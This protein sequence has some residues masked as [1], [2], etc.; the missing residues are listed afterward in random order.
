M[1][2]KR[3]SKDGKIRKEDNFQ[4]PDNRNIF[5]YLTLG[6]SFLISFV[7]YVLTLAPSV[8]FED[9]GELI[10][11]AVHLGV[12]HEPGYPLYTM[13]GKLFSWLPVGDMAY[14]LN[15][16]SA[17]FSSL[18]AIL[19]CRSTILII[20]SLSRN[21]L[22]SLQIRII[23]Y[24]IGLFAAL[25]FAFSFENWEQSVITEV[26]GLHMFFVGL[27]VML[28]VLW[29]Q[30]LTMLEKEKYFYTIAFSTGLS[31]TNHSTALLFIPVFVLYVL[32]V[33]Y[34]FLLNLKRI[35]RGIL[36]G[37][38]GLLP[39]LYLPL[40]SLRDPVLD[41][42][43]PETFTNFIRT[44]SRHQY[45][46]LAQTSEKFLNGLQFYFGKLLL[47]QWFSFLLLL[48]IPASI[49]LYKHNRKI[50]YF[51]LLFLLFYV[52]VT[53][54]LTDFEVVGKGFYFNLNRLLVTVFYIPSYLM[55]SVLMGIG[56]F[57]VIGLLKNTN[58]K[59]GMLGVFM[60]LPFIVLTM[61]YKT[62][63]MSKFTYPTTYLNNLFNVVTKDAL[64]LTQIDYF[65]FPAMY[66]QVVEGNRT[67][68]T[69]L[70]QPLLKRTWYIDML[71]E[72]NKEFINESKPAV[73]KF[74]KAVAPFEA[75]KPYD[76]NYIE[77]C[78]I[79]MINSFIDQTIANGRDV[80]FTYLPQKEILR[81]YALESVLGAYKLNKGNTFTFVKEEE[82]KLNEF[83][84]L[85]EDDPLLVRT[86]SDF[87]GSLHIL[88]AT[89]Y[90]GE[91]LTDKALE[92]YKSGLEFYLEKPEVR[93]F[94]NQ[95]IMV[96]GQ[97]Q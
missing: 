22:D 4:Y 64:V 80:F 87:Y 24:C 83:R 71:K 45:T 12:P 70:D 92:Y 73:E 95:K 47:D 37:V 55:I 59:F 94:A 18:A 29:S 66:Y 20:E 27:F 10:T 90:E 57:Y 19:V 91:G 79:G 23:K 39:L 11:A 34:T 41:W 50:L 1:S 72:H 86:V 21:D 7:V 89:W 14:R 68:V 84:G 25:V 36:A 88:R 75:R 67:D 81:N 54:Y 38:L 78:Y 65:Y 44:I 35:G 13:L 49:D 74:L 48:L 56:I 60:I 3:K 2:K 96:L 40:A 43:N 77:S 15:L 9:S 17:F 63:D 82:L 6:L 31:L 42:G 61:N 58:Q 28:V 30:K 16:M 85:S 26:Y 69:V 53:T 97:H 51:S 52:P 32:I 5:F 33:D 76:G 93:K 46:E 62:V 8:T